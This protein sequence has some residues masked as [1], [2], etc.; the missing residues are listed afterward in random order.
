MSTDTSVH[1]KVLAVRD[2]LTN[3]LIDRAEA[4]DAAILALLVRAHLL[5][6]GPPGTAKSLLVREVTSRIVGAT[7][8][9]RLLTTQYYDENRARYIE[10]EPCPADEQ[11]DGISF[12]ERAAYGGYFDSGFR[13]EP[14]PWA[15]NTGCRAG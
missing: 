14:E 4:I 12:T 11:W 9:E 6:L 7:Y 3:N 13:S 15:I 5:L 1:A 8:F 10:A 2:D